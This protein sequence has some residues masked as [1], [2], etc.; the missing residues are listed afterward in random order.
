MR[1][2]I[3]VNRLERY[4]QMLSDCNQILLR[5]DDEEI[6]AQKICDTI[7]NVGR[8]DSAFFGLLK[9]NKL[10]LNV[11]KGVLTPYADEIKIILDDPQHSSGASARALKDG[12]IHIY[13]DVTHEKDY[14]PYREIIDKTGLKANMAVPIKVEDKVI[15]TL[16]IYS[17][18][19]GAF[20]E[21]EKKLF[22]EL[23]GDLAYGISAIR[24]RKKT[25]SLNE[26]LKRIRMANQRIAKENN[27]ERLL[28]GFCEDLAGAK[29]YYGVALYYNEKIYFAGDCL[30]NV[31]ENVESGKLDLKGYTEDLEITDYKCPAHPDSKLAFMKIK[32]GDRTYAI[33]FA[34][35]IE[36]VFEDQDQ[37]ALLK[38]LAGDLGVGIDRILNRS[39]ALTFGKVVQ[40]LS[41]GIHLIDPDTLRFKL[42]NS[43]AL[44]RLG[45][46]PE[47]MKEMTPADIKP[48]FTLEQLKEMFEPLKYHKRDYIQFETVHKRKDGTT[49][50]VMISVFYNDDP[51]NPSYVAIGTDLSGTKGLEFKINSL[52][53]ALVVALSDMVEVKDPYT[54]GHQR[55]V[56]M[57][58]VEIAK[59]MG[60]NDNETQLIKI[61]GLL[62]DIGKISIPL[63]ILTKPS[64]LKRTEFELIKDHVEEGYKILKN[65]TDFDEIA[66]MVRQHHERINGSGYPS[67]IN[68]DEMTIGGRILAVADVVEAMASHR[69]YRAALGIDAALDEINVNSNVLYDAD[70]VKSCER[71]FESGWNFDT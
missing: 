17:K 51:I 65:I 16:G 23:G 20:T 44:K 42:V 4:F 39:D 61:A 29:F 40:N 48:E 49:Y 2:R 31:K 67:G 47:E 46:T 15:G 45:Y 13:N 63:D 57:L 3:Q 66:I 26:M 37:I 33:L 52:V 34:C 35:A 56:S 7:V 12:Q 69:P 64:K 1:G 38:E 24:T 36:E 18:M 32:S 41:E 59:E 55:R 10:E 50:P 22:E 8:F 60:L 70:V 30:F 68:G 25:E 53:D 27:L 58:A 19:V 21:T 71:V 6:L 62:H 54:A 28:Q 14:D 11:V 9:G 43:S 5:A